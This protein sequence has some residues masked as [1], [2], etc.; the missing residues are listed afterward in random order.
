MASLSLQRIGELIKLPVW[1]DAVA[2]ILG[3]TVG[4]RIGPDGFLRLE[5]IVNVGTEIHYTDYGG[6]VLPYHRNPSVRLAIAV[7]LVSDGCYPVWSILDTDSRSL[8]RMVN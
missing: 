6:A 2:G 4:V 7:K 1:E 5:A 3:Q 8:V